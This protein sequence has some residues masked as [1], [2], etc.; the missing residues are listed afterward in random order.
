[1]AT[2]THQLHRDGLHATCRGNQAIVID[3]NCKLSP[4]S[5]PGILSYPPTFFD[6]NC[7]P[8]GPNDHNGK[9]KKRTGIR[10]MRAPSWAAAGWAGGHMLAL[11]ILNR[12]FFP[13]PRTAP[14]PCRQVS[15]YVTLTSDIYSD[16]LQCQ[17]TSKGI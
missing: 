13:L 14:S 11:P 6:I 16:R 1:M 8:Q 10:N 7:C 3:G 2:R 17:K 5:C 4:Y 12:Y 15:V 9:S